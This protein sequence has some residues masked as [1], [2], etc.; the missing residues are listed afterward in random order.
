[1]GD[2][3]KKWREIVSLLKGSCD[4]LHN[5]LWNSD[6]L[7]EEGF[8]FAESWRKRS[9]SEQKERVNKVNLRNPSIRS[10]MLRSF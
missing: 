8:D 1:M 5:L 10:E 2:R 3:K 7:A 9:K 6:A 4:I